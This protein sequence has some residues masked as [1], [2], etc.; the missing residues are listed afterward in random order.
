MIFDVIYT[1]SSE[2]SW[3]SSCEQ[4]LYVQVVVSGSVMNFLLTRGLSQHHAGFLRYVVIRAIFPEFRHNW[5]DSPNFVISI[6]VNWLSRRG[7]GQHLQLSRTVT[8]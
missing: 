4:A 2:I 8:L 1:R 3:K 5:T 6:P 7:P